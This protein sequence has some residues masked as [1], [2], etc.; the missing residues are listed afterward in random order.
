MKYNT[1]SSSGFMPA[2]ELSAFCKLSHLIVILL[3]RYA[4]PPPTARQEL[5]A[6]LRSNFL[7]LTWF[8]SGR[9]YNVGT[10]H[11]VIWPI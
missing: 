8:A 1:I 10:N 11:Y 5:E 3:W 7:R 9:D 4:L 2:A 6:G